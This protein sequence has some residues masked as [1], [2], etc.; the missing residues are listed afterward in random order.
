LD[1]Q[2]DQYSR[3]SVVLETAEGKIV[4]RIQGLMS[5]SAR[6]DRIIPIHLPPE[7]LPKGDYVLTLSG[8]EPHSMSQVVD[9]YSFTV[10][11]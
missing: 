7:A 1:L 8:T 2:S 6:G 5:Q 10:S 3:Y 9:S 11:R 4:R